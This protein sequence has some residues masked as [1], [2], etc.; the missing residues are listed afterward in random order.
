MLQ[1]T[2]RVKDGEELLAYYTKQY[3]EYRFSIKFVNNRVGYMN[4]F[5]VKNQRERPDF[6]DRGKVY[7]IRTMQLVVGAVPLLRLRT[8]IEII[9]S[10]VLPT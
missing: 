7:D 10:W 9:W 2:G 5:W 6:P 4:R 1:N 8:M 3:E